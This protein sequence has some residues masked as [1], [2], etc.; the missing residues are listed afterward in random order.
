MG[1][2]YTSLDS[3]KIKEEHYKHIYQMSFKY[4]EYDNDIYQQSF[5]G[6]FKVI[7]DNPIHA[8]NII[9]G[10]L[11]KLQENVDKGDHYTHHT[12]IIIIYNKLKDINLVNL[13]EYYIQKILNN[14]YTPLQVLNDDNACTSKSCNCSNSLIAYDDKIVY[15]HNNTYTQSNINNDNLNNNDNNDNNNDDY[16]DYDDDYVDDDKDYYNSYSY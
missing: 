9:L 7:S 5:D 4:N 2:D 15:N 10:F 11:L 1:F 3:D 13:C 12:N 8:R 14:E 6:I 16:D